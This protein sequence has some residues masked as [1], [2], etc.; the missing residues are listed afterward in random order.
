[1]RRARHAIRPHSP[2]S[3]RKC[4]QPTPSRCSG[5]VAVSKAVSPRNPVVTQVECRR[6]SYGH[7]VARG[8]NSILL[9]DPELLPRTT[10]SD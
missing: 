5:L 4:V 10:S 7:V 8:V 2:E 3:T 6:A 1:M 9:T